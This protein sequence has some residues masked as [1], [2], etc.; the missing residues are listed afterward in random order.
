MEA[1]MEFLHGKALTV[2]MADLCRTR[3]SLKIAIAYWG[4]S[5]LKLLH[6]NPARTNVKLLCCLKGGKSDPDIIGRF[7]T[8]A[9]QRDNLHAKV[10]WTPHGAIVGSANASSNGLP[11]EEDSADGL[12]EAGIFVTDDTTLRAI[13]QWF[14]RQYKS[15]RHIAKADLNAARAA[16]SRRVWKASAL[17]RPRK[18]SLIEA[19]KT[20][21]KLE[22]GE[23]RI[24]F[25]LS[26]QFSTPKE[27]RGEKE[28][29]KNNSSKI[30]DSLKLPRERFN[31]LRWYSE[32]R[33]LPTNTF[34]I[35][36]DIKNGRI[37]DI[38]IE[39]TFDVKKRWRIKGV[40]DNVTYIL[41]SG[42]QGFN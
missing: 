34:L 33:N 18:Q 32:W 10:I 23:Q 1:A 28:F 3:T 31:N 9:R 35:T 40:G 2:R 12:I 19:L 29:R 17:T 30:E 14:D 5:S 27:N 25:V 4:Q 6:L 15:A 24:A 26:K 22:F 36:C 38:Y 41:D 37:S 13:E 16:R 20:G 39:K 42:F 7:H 21:G 8:R 11:E